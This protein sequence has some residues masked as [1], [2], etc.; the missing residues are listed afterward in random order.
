MKNRFIASH[1][2][3][4]IP[5]VITMPT[6][7]FSQ[8]LETGKFAIQ[9]ANTSNPVLWFLSDP[10]A[11]AV[12]APFGS[13]VQGVRAF[14]DWVKKSANSDALPSFGNSLSLN[15]WEYVV[16]S[17]LRANRFSFSQAQALYAARARGDKLSSA[18]GKQVGQATYSIRGSHVE[19]R[20]PKDLMLGDVIL[21]DEGGH[22]VQLTGER[23]AAQRNKVI[24]FS[25]RPIWGD[26][27]REVPLDSVKPEVTTI[28]SLI[29]EMIELY[30]DV[31]T[32][33]QNI[34]L[35]IIRF[36]DSSIGE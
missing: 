28:E 13:R 29:E 24:S 36:S 2:H 3:K 23:D 4:L 17:M 30:P 18:L 7:G 19:M 11:Q 9:A 32:D 22:V 6:Y 25:P 35:K 15:C 12:W 34:S 10:G 21:M 14:E 26:G 5:L 16:Y 27:S 8:S 31:P 1:I 20:W 33:W